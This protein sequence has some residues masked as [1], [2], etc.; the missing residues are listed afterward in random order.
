MKNTEISFLAQLP[1]L[2][3]AKNSAPTVDDC[4]NLVINPAN[5]ALVP[6][7]Y[8][9][10]KDAQFGTRLTAFA[11]DDGQMSLIHSGLSL[12]I[13]NL[14]T[15]EYQSVGLLS[16]EP[17]SAVALSASELLVFTSQGSTRV[18]NS[19]GS[20]TILEEMTQ[21]P[22]F[23]LEVVDTTVYNALIP[24]GTLTGSYLHGTGSLSKADAQSL[25][26][27]LLSTYHS[28]AEKARADGYMIQPVLARIR[29][30]D[31]YFNVKFTGPTVLLGQFQLTDALEISANV[32]A[33]TRAVTAIQASAYN[34]GVRIPD[35]LPDG[36]QKHI[37]G[38]EVQTS[39]PLH[40]LDYAASLNG[41]VL[42]D[43][44]GTSSTITCALPGVATD[45][46]GELQR[47][48]VVWQSLSRLDSLLTTRSIKALSDEMAGKLITVNISTQDPQQE[49]EALTKALSKKVSQA[50]GY[51]A[52]VA[53]NCSEPHRF[54]ATACALN[55]DTVL[56][57]NPTPVRYEGF[58]LTAM[59]TS[60]GI[61]AWHAYAQVAL[62]DGSEK[63]VW[64]GQGSSLAPLALSPIL[65]Y[66]SP[67]ATQMTI[68]ILNSEGTI[69][70]QTLPLTPDDAGRASYYIHPSLE[71]WLPSTTASVYLIPAE[72][73]VATCH[74][75]V[76]F[77]TLAS[78]PLEPI[79]ALLA[80]PCA[81]SAL[82]PA[83][84]SSSS[85]DYGKSHF[86][87]FS[88]FGVT[89]IGVGTTRTLSGANRISQLPVS[90]PQQV[91]WTDSA[92][93]A[94]SDTVTLF[95]VS[96]NRSTPL[97]C[98]S[99]SWEGAVPSAAIT[100]YATP[101]VAL[102]SF[103]NPLLITTQKSVTS[104]L[105]PDSLSFTRVTPDDGTDTI[106]IL[107]QARIP[108]STPIRAANFDLAASL[109]QGSI[110][111]SLD[112]GQQPD[113]SLPLLRL[114]IDSEVNAPLYYPVT[115]P[116]RGWATVSIEARVSPD[117]LFRKINLL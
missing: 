47:Q 105:S 33:A 45:R 6:L 85:W 72:Q 51:T 16:N 14:A 40:I 59:A 100:A 75:G 77:N 89:A 79:S 28:L 82:T 106:P 18:V 54:T 65:S 12:Y 92:V 88:R 27:D 11:T 29:L 87:A 64:S 68:A 22:A 74:D 90:T 103:K 38:L 20:W 86:Y 31:E 71:P 69:L 76:V 46:G 35:T 78:N 99:T 7:Q 63:V 52:V 114:D 55:G 21:P 94:I 48:A 84:R 53:R 113:G 2:K 3:Q 58:P 9:P 83:A 96:G 15:G 10:S 102:P 39:T 57:A 108:L 24:E 81:I 116:F 49:R 80:A 95:S 97:S 26:N 5:G 115:A 4:Q 1:S 107:W 104:L 44:T 23:S 30:I 117:F 93:Y 111:L 37:W 101:P 25:R 67:D 19:D 62:S 42:A 112:N 8:E 70:K 50:T 32:T 56:V 110:T 13:V 34:I 43:S 91:V 66:P 109:F 73:R 41:S 98:V 17:T 60:R 36:W 61:G